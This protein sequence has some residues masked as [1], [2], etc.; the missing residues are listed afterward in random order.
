MNAFQ[1]GQSKQRLKLEEQKFRTTVRL[2]RATVA[3]SVESCSA[4]NAGNLAIAA[5]LQQTLPDNAPVA[6]LV[7]SIEAIE[8]GSRERLQGIME[9]LKELGGGE[10][11]VE[12][13]KAGGE[14]AGSDENDTSG[15][16]QGS[17]DEEQE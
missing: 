12:A 10:E 14:G 15:S 9:Q 8:S 11:D 7:K 17:D 4:M 5:V 1:L 2:E 16:E 3:I 13:D 6:K